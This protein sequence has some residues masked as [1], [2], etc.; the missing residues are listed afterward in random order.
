MDFSFRKLVL[1]TFF[2]IYSKN[3]NLKITHKDNINLIHTCTL[4][5]R[6]T[7]DQSGMLNDTPH[8]LP[9]A[10]VLWESGQ[11]KAKCK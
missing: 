7:S 4:K 3:N 6:K 2:Q 1:D 8:S 9:F 10:N 5:N 11:R